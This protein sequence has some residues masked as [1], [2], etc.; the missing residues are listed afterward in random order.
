[1]TFKDR[2]LQRPSVNENRDS[3]ALPNFS[4]EGDARPLVST[5]RLFR[6]WQDEE[7]QYDPGYEYTEGDVRKEL[8]I[9][10]CFSLVQDDGQEANTM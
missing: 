4:F 8:D 10:V 7:S 3:L 9:I 2:L 5:E 6:Q 1:M